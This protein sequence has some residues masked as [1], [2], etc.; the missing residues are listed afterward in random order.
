MSANGSDRGLDRAHADG[1]GCDV[2]LGGS[3]PPP[4]SPKRLPPILSRTVSARRPTP[5]SLARGVHWTMSNATKSGTTR[6]LNGSRAAASA[7]F[8]LPCRGSA[9]PCPR[10]RRPRAARRRCR[11][12]AHSK[13]RDLRCR[14]GNAPAPE[15]ST[16]SAPSLSAPSLSDPLAASASEPTRAP[17]NNPSLRVLS[18]GN[19]ARIRFA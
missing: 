2:T 7:S 14:Q 8:N 19:E 6:I 18:L 11:R 13:K 16:A 17:A 3:G 12:P 1:V 10:D 9:R 5:H 4:R 15:K